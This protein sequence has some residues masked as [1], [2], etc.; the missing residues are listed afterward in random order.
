M[1]FLVIVIVILCYSLCVYS[2]EGDLKT[3]KGT[4]PSVDKLR[5]KYNTK[6]K[7]VDRLYDLII[8]KH[9]A[10]VWNKNL[11][12]AIVFSIVLAYIT[13]MDMKSLFISIFVMFI[14][15]DLPNRWISAHINTPIFG[16]ASVLYGFHN[17]TSHSLLPH[18]FF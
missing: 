12:I 18:N 17:S 1:I 5:K 9:N 13:K 8:M 15:V 11:G 3:A 10:V 14:A 16:E 2:P 6:K 7:I 4:V